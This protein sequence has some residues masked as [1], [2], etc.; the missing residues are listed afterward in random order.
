MG[1]IKDGDKYLQML[2]N[3]YPA[4]YRKEV[5][6]VCIAAIVEA[7]VRYICAM[8]EVRYDAGIGTQKSK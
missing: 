4:K 6:H 7:Q 8:K 3:K 2:L 5:I 1:N